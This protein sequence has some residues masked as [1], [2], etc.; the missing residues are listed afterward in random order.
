MSDS[1]LRPRPRREPGYVEFICLVGGMMSLVSVAIDSL[2]PA[3]PVIQVSFGLAGPTS[4][5]HLLTAFM[6]G[7]GIMQFAYGLISDSIGRKPVLMA[8]LVLFGIGTI[9]TLAAQG[10]ELLLVGRAVQGMGAAAA[11]VLV[12]AIVRDR[13]AGREMARAISLTMTIFIIVQMLAPILGQFIMIA[14]SW[15]AILVLMMGLALIQMLWF[16]FRMPETL[17][18]QHRHA[19]SLQQVSTAVRTCL[20]AR[21][22]VSYAL[23]MAFMQSTLLGYLGCSPALFGPSLYNLGPFFGAAFAAIAGAMGLASFV[24]AWLVNRIGMRRVGHAGLCGFILIALLQ[25]AITIACDGRPPFEVFISILTVAMF[26][27]SLTAPNLNAM[28]MQP[29]GQVAGTAASLVGSNANILGGLLGAVIGFAFDGT[30]VPL[31]IG[32]LALSAGALGVVLWTERGRLFEADPGSPSTAA[33]IA[34]K[35][36][37]NERTF[38]CQT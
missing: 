30:T 29:V 36:T 15:Q 32:F 38:G 7:F 11:R 31:A 22:F 18:P 27:F 19:L 9:L 2:L 21:G 10:Y 3:F 26:L 34:A 8:G 6:V 13:F 37:G 4:A 35:A 28:A 17:Q 24:N 14:A 25:L 16:G 20:Q 5:Q 12:D 23:A 33:A 1:S